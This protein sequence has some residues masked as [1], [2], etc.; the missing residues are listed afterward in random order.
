MAE[1]IIT[2]KDL[3]ENQKVGLLTSGIAGIASGLIKIP[4]GVF[5]LGAELL[6]N[7]FL[8]DNFF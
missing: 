8:L 7:H 2:E 4:K 5:S 6:D 3:E 1:Y